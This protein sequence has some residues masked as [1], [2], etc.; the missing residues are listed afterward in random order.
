[1]I[2]ISITKQKILKEIKDEPLHGYEISQRLDLQTSTI[3]QH[4]NELEEAGYV[5]C[6]KRADRV[7]YHLTKRG[8]ILTKALFEDL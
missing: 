3:Y 6:E 5:D 1:M 4:L 2:P 8:K 7:I